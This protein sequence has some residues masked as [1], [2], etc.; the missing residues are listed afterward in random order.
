MKK[1][2][3]LVSSLIVVLSAASFAGKGGDDQCN[4]DRKGTHGGAWKALNLTDKQKQQLKDLR[5]EGKSEIKEHFKNVREIREKIKD[6]LLK[7]KPDKKALEKY[8]EQLGKLH[9]E[10][11]INKT[12]HMLKVK[13]ILSPEQFKMLL[14]K[15]NRLRMGSRNHRKSRQHRKHHSDAPSPPDHPEFDE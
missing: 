4:H 1:Y 10:M 2:L 11:H 3:F 14:E 6:E 7:E 12:D 15:E 5:E 8:G 9:V 13:E